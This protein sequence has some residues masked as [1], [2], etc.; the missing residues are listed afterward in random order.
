MQLAD[1]LAKIN[2]KIL[3]V[4]ESKFLTATLKEKV[5][6]GVKRYRLKAVD[7]CASKFGANAGAHLVS[8]IFGVGKSKYLG[9]T[10]MALL[11]QTCDATSQDRSFAGSRPC[12]HHHRPVY[13]FDGFGLV[14]VREELDGRRSALGNRHWGEDSREGRGNLRKIFAAR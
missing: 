7:V 9:G 2:P 4:E 11:N 12:Q 14:L 5:A 10:R 8:C 6:I 3:V 1:A 13:V